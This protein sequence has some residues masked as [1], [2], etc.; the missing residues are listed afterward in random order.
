MATV[1]DNCI[2]GRPRYRAATYQD[3]PIR[4]VALMDILLVKCTCGACQKIP[5]KS[6]QKHYAVFCP[7]GSQ[8]R[9]NDEFLDM[10]TRLRVSGVRR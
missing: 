4:L 2:E 3:G 9:L 8:S 6:V 5:L 10:W 1:N 7:C